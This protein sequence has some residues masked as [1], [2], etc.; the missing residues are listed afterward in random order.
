MLR[1]YRAFNLV[2]SPSSNKILWPSCDLDV[3][4]YVAVLAGHLG[5]AELLAKLRLKLRQWTSIKILLVI[6]FQDSSQSQMILASAINQ[7]VVPWQPL[8]PPLLL[9]LKITPPKRGSYNKEKGYE[10][11]RGAEIQSWVQA[12]CPSRTQVRKLGSE[13]E[14]VW[15]SVIPDLS[16]RLLCDAR[17]KF[18]VVGVTEIRMQS[19]YCH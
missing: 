19:H 6:L 17:Q 11:G 14:N 4:A 8:C 15:Q 16:V 3:F 12:F 9:A 13:S 18:P 10:V 1:C 2:P 5:D 7:L